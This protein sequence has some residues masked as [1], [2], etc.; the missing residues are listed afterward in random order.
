MRKMILPVA[1]L[2]SAAVLLAAQNQNPTVVPLNVNPGLWQV[3]MTTTIKGLPPNTNTYRSC[4][5]KEDL[6][7]YPFTDPKAMCTW[8]VASSTGSNMQAKGTCMPGDMGKVDFNMQL[9]ATD[10]SNVTGT[11][12]MT[13]NG[14]RGPMQ[15]DYSAT[16]KW[17]GA[18][19][20]AGMK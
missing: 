1:V 17:I 8:T 20:P 7:K 16:A 9:T 18:T 19:C 4:V 11:G 2:L 15:G 6:A 3:T 13:V 12:Q 5:K 14:P 10:S